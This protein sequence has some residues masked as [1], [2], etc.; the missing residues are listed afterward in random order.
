MKLT[1]KTILILLALSAVTATFAQTNRERH[2][3]RDRGSDS[4]G[5]NSASGNH[6]PAPTDYEAFTGF[7]SDRNIFDPNRQP[8]YSGGSRPITRRVRSDAP[9]LSL[10]G[11]MSYNKG[12]FAFFNGNDEDLKQVVTVSGKID[13]YTVAELNTGRVK[14]VANDK[15][16]TLDLKVGDV[17][18]QID[19][20]WKLTGGELPEETSTAPAA[21]ADNST[22]TD[23]AAPV[24]G[25]ADQPN[26]TLK[27]LMELREKENQ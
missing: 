13:H 20:Q 27:R 24:P 9:F 3:Y 4:S 23:T 26:A 19:G 21:G 17:L 16:E 18:R 22:A 12:M 1:S 8:H 7:I 2:R 14:L 25:S 6:V 15:K 11:I 10:V 5:S